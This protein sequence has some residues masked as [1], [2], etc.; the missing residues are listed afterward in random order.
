MIAMPASSRSTFTKRRSPWRS[1]M[2]GQEAPEYRGEIKNTPKAMAKLVRRLSE[3]GELFLFCYEAGPCRYGLYRQIV[4]MGHDCEVAAAPKSEALKTDRR[5]A[6]RLARLLRAGELTRVWVPDTEQ[7]AMRDLWRC[8]GDFKIQ[9]R[10]ARQQLNGFVLRHGHH[11][12][13]A[14]P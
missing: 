3:H 13:R 5:G 1:L 11:W 7:E 12:C 6:L 2:R 10:K 14:T 9:E 8:R 4:E